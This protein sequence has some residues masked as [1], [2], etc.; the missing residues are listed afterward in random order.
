MTTPADLPEPKSLAGFAEDARKETGMGLVCPKCGCIQFSDGKNV[1]NTVRVDGAVRR[2]RVC[3]N[4][5]RIWT[6]TE[7]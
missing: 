7:R 1:R 5:G 3:R 4:Y 6:T 2:Y